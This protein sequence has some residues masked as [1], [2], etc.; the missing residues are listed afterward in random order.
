MQHA[1]LCRVQK[2]K[3]FQDYRQN[4]AMTRTMLISIKP[5]CTVQDFTISHYTE[6]TCFRLHHRYTEA[7]ILAGK[8]NGRALR[9]RR[10]RG[11]IKKTGKN[12]KMREYQPASHLLVR[13]GDIGEGKYHWAGPC[14]ALNTV[15]SSRNA[16]SLPLV[17][18]LFINMFINLFINVWNIKHTSS[19]ASKKKKKLNRGKGKQSLT[20]SSQAA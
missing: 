20:T 10:D 11:P 13:Y 18:H 9:D 8:A 12:E 19:R 2:Y 16:I 4:S 6:V 3:T 5:I 7:S 17:P 14:I 15:V 1:S